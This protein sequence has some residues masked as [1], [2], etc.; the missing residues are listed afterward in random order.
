MRLGS[1]TASEE[2]SALLMGID[3]ALYSTFIFL[4]VTRHGKY[5][6]MHHC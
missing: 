6:E 2:A 3:F 4:L 5:I 1:S